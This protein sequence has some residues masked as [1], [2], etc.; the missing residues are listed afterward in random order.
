MADI[1]IWSSLLQK[2][3]I[4]S[5]ALHQLPIYS[6]YYIH[7]LVILNFHFLVK[8]LIS[9]VAFLSGLLQDPCRIRVYNFS[10]LTEC[11]IGD[12]LQNFSDSQVI[13]DMVHLY[14]LMYEASLSLNNY[15]GIILLVENL[16]AMLIRRSWTDRRFDMNQLEIITMQI[17]HCRIRFT[18]AGL[19]EI[20]RRIVTSIAAGVTT[21]LIILIQFNTTE[22]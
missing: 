11:I 1:C 17:F 7:L 14:D 9:R 3:Q 2:H 5:Y 21:Y 8:L 20:N 6:M 13:D 10:V 4:M 18:A 16:S 19:T 12:Q 22:R 15:Y